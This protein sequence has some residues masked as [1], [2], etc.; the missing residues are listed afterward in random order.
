MIKIGK[1]DTKE[2]LLIKLR[3]VE[4]KLKK[5]QAQGKK[6]FIHFAKI[7]QVTGD[8]A[9]L[10]K[11]ITELQ[12]ALFQPPTTTKTATKILRLKK[13]LTREEQQLENAIAFADHLNRKQEYSIAQEDIAQLTARLL[14]LNT[15]HEK[16]SFVQGCIVK[17][18]LLSV[19]EL[20]TFINEGVAE[21]L[22]QF[23]TDHVPSVTFCL[24]KDLAKNKIKHTLNIH[25]EMMGDVYDGIRSLSKGERKRAKLATMLGMYNVV[26]R[27]NQLFPQGLFLLDECLSNLDSD[28]QTTI[29]SQLKNKGG[30]F[31]I[32]S[33]DATKG[34][35]DSVV[36][37]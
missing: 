20:I 34:I 25:V 21:M 18:E 32:V 15:Q 35:F 4:E 17:A 30:L 8:V 3:A 37:W 2:S 16:L 36:S 28:T 13:K 5:I 23:F 29:L 1:V 27:G 7:D 19:E 33:H 10:E 9:S 14:E 31:L 26:G 24:E 11:N 6:S 12:Q 22:A